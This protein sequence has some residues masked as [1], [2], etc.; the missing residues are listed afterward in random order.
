MA[1]TAAMATIL[2]REG[3]FYLY[4]YWELNGSMAVN[5]DGINARRRR[6]VLSLAGGVSLGVVVVGKQRRS[7]TWS[8]KHMSA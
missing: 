4:K 6:W 1:P 7:M 3:I 2:V 8:L 5:Y